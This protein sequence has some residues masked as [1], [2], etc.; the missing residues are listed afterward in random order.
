MIW[1][2][3]IRKWSRTIH[4][5]LSY[6]FSG[7][8]LVYVISGFMLN[9]KDDFN[10]DYS[11]SI[12]KYSMPDYF[13]TRKSEITNKSVINL[14]EKWNETENYAKHYF[15]NDNEI[16]VFLKGGSL[17]T[18]N[19]SERLIQYES[20]KKRTFLSALNRLHYNPSLAWT[21]FSD[22]FLISMFIIII[23]GLIMVKGKYGI[24]GR[25]GIELAIGIVLPFIFMFIL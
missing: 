3:T 5:D 21:I 13:P 12:H 11:I 8:L 6:F 9:H 22:I 17:M 24:L 16:K 4:R 23:S 2:S 20:I 18:V 19:L 14:L 25:G 1:Y 7:I 15:P 10:S